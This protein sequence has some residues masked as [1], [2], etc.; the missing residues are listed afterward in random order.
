MSK[1]PLNT[2]IVDT[3]SPNQINAF[4]LSVY[5]SLGEGVITEMELELHNGNLKLNPE[6]SKKFR[7]VA[8]LS[9]EINDRYNSKFDFGTVELINKKL[10]HIDN[11][12]RY[13]NALD[14][15]SIKLLEQVAEMFYH[16]RIAD[17]E[18]ITPKTKETTLEKYFKKIK[19]IFKVA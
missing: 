8:E 18:N 19:T 12:A 10:I 6:L 15:E 5:A 4:M 2:K 16:Q 11:I 9:K 13:S 17:L 14:L 1:E 3:L 7:K